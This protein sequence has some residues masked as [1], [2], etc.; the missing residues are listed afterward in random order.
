MNGILVVDKPQD[1]TSHD[2]VNFIRRRFKI[3]RVGHTG[4][5]DPMATGV[6]VLLLGEYTKFSSEFSGDTKEYKT[7]LTLGR[8]TDT[9]DAT[10]RV[11]KQ[12][13]LPELRKEAV[14][15]TLKKFTGDIQ[16]IP[17]MVSAVKINGQKLYNLARQGKEIQRKPRPV[18]ISNLRLDSF[19]PPDIAM[20]I[21]CS[22]GTYVRTL[23]EDIAEGLGC[24]GCMSYL[25][26]VRAGQF[27]IG[28]AIA[29]E[30]LREIPQQDLGN[31]IL[32]RWA[33]KP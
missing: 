24:C 29:V 19:A 15:E 20:S 17:P 2:V 7:V 26:R 18:C 23:C 8:A 31:L 9:G 28:Q 13:P 16:Q 25:R 21:V 32:N 30:K 6:L 3:K 27:L 11:I 5:L 4:T 14:E 22:K 1:W 12:R 10:G 33:E